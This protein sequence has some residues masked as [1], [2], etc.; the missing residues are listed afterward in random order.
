MIVL[1]KYCCCG[2]IE[3]DDT[4]TEGGEDFGGET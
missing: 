2:Q 4:D 3:N 1:I